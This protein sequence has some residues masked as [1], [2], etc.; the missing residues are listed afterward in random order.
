M[1]A[2]QA[3]GKFNAL[4]GNRA[5]ALLSDHIRTD[6]ALALHRRRRA[7]LK[8]IGRDAPRLLPSA[9]L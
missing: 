1:H 3:N 6:G 8:G 7:D 5:G 2:R 9:D 4:D